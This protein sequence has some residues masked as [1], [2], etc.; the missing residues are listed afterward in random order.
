MDKPQRAV[1]SY[2]RA[3]LLY[4]EVDDW[5][6]TAFVFFQSGIVYYRLGNVS[7]ALELSG[8]ALSIFEAHDVGNE[9]GNE[10]GKA[11]ALH[12][13]GLAC[14]QLGETQ[15]ALESINKSWT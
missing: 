13:M 6:N 10:E 12:L 2:K 7:E 8:W 11:N 5:K 1:E 14:F 9:E 3:L 4:K 15:R